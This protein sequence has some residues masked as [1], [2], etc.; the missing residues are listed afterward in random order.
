ME[1]SMHRVA[2]ELRET[3][4]RLRCCLEGLCASSK[5]GEYTA[6]AP[7]PDEISALLS[8][9]LR[10]GEWLRRR[11][12]APDPALEFELTQYR[13][14]VERLRTMLPLMH[15][16]L[17]QERARLEQEGQRLNAAA[18]WAHVSRQTLG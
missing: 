9:L 6:R 12:A 10:A 16:A 15:R 11:P 1:I 4:R 18:H 8:E 2:V 14:Q 5:A 13:E 17:L 7:T 3:N